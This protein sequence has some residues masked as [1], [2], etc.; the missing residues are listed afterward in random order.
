M[1]EIRT[2]ASTFAVLRRL[3]AG[4]GPLWWYGALLFAVNRIGDVVNLYTGAFLIPALVPE[5]DLGA[6]PPLLKLAGFIAT[7]V[8]L[9][10][11][12]AEKY[13]NVFAG[14]GEIGRAKALLRDAS[15]VALAFPAVVAAA[16]LVRPGPILERMSI[17][18]PRLLV[19]AVLL[20]ALGC[21]KPLFLSAAR[22]FGTYSTV[23][24]AGVPGP[25]V[26]LAAM[27]L[28][29][30]MWPLRGFLMAQALGDAAGLA[31]VVWAVLR[32]LRAQRDPLEGYG[33]YHGEMLRYAVPPVL[34]SMLVAAQ[35][36]IEAFVIRQRLPASDSAANYFI[37]MLAMI[38]FYFGDAIT[39][40]LFPVISSRYE[41]G[42]KTGTVLAQTMAISLL[43]G[44]GSTALLFVFSPWVLSLREAWRG[45]LPFAGLVAV[46]ALGRT[47]RMTA[48]CFVLHEQ[49]CRRFGFLWHYGTLLAVSAVGLYALVGWGA[50][51][52]I[53][54]ERLWAA[55][56]AWPRATL[57]FILCWGAAWNGAM[58]LAVL[59]QLM[60][61]RY[62]KRT[63]ADPRTP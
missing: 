35:G 38:P 14:R 32:F 37:E 56:D 62:A 9:L 41:H 44:L 42:E 3:K 51:Q 33:A 48:N 10:V 29:A 12:P 36:F 6:V 20:G 49:A 8:G 34:C 43:L 19:F 21:V 39:A 55:V 24:W 23:V 50:F 52:G 57:P 5:A 30:R 59:V 31:L 46:V 47:F 16:L 1:A 11:L 40:F 26:R 61:R 13:M 15:C 17:A 22:A 7:P 4:L 45:A 58:L 60:A 25:F 18:D 28:L 54:P 27:W 53:L 2:R 63:G